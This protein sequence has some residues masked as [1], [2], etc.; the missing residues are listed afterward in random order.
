M[1]TIVSYFK[2]LYW[3]FHGEIV[4]NVKNFVKDNLQTVRYYR[5]IFSRALR[6]YSLN[7]DG[8]KTYKVTISPN[9]EG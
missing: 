1:K 6:N 7:W 3:Y 8:I 4:E 9:T 2:A 5:R